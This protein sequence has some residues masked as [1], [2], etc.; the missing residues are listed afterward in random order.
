MVGEDE[1]I[2]NDNILPSTRSKNN[3]LGDI[4]WSQWLTAAAKWLDTSD[5]NDWQVTRK[6]LRINGISLDLVTTKP[7]HRK[8]SLDL[9]RIDANNADPLCDQ[10]LPQA[11]GKGPHGRL[12]RAVDAAADVRLTAG[13]GANVDDVACALAVVALQHRRQDSLRHVDQACHVGREHD[14]NV[15]F[16]NL[17][18]LGYSLDE[19]TIRRVC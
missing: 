16:L 6:H 19:T 5:K 13:D 3:S 1:C 9:A 2:S 7:N 8:L 11:L 12:G 4:I 17:W 10:L 18:R 14:V 15:I